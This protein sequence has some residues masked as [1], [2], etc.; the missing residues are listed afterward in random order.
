MAMVTKPKRFEVYLIN[1]DPTQG[2]EI[3]K[4]R[5]CMIISPDEMNKY[6]HTLIVLPMTSQ[7]KQYPTR[8]PCHFDGK[9]GLIILDQ[10]RTID[11]ARLVKKL[12]TIDYVVGKKV[13]LS[14][15]AMFEE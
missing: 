5:P 11:K 6:L 13:L 9:D 14:L 1:L 8:I 2:S 3:Q 12:G 7:G 4:T 10:I 15:K